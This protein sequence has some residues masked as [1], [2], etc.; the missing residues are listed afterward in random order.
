MGRSFRL[1][2]Y[3]LHRQRGPSRAGVRYRGV[4]ES[5]GLR[6]RERG[7]D[8]E[9]KVASSLL[10]VRMSSKPE[11]PPVLFVTAEPGASPKHFHLD[12]KFPIYALD[13]IDPT[14]VVL[15]GGGGSSRSGVKNR[16]VRPPAAFRSG[17]DRV[18]CSP[19]LPAHP[20]S[21]TTS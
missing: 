8:Q 13:F 21:C 3:Q 10:F 12:L 11:P 16:L 20:P 5:Q 9:L 7:R 4:R 2:A 18:W 19:V 15:G 17:G 1:N 14:T 6:A